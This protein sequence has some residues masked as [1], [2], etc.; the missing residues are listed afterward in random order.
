MVQ[1]FKRPNGSWQLEIGSWQLAKKVKSDIRRFN[2]S[3]V[4]RSFKRPV[5]SWQLA[6]KSKK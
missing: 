6:K 1:K 4:Q 5:G 2:G 3:K